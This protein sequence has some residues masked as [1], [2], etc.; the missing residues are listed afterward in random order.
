MNSTSCSASWNSRTT[1]RANRERPRRN[2]GR[3]SRALHGHVRATRNRHAPHRKVASDAART[4]R[5]HPRPHH[6]PGHT[7]TT[8]AVATK[9]QRS[10]SWPSMNMAETIPT[11]GRVLNRSGTA[12]PTSTRVV[13]ARPGDTTRANQNQPNHPVQRMGETMCSLQEH[14]EREIRARKAQPETTDPTKSAAEQGG[15]SLPETDPAPQEQS[16]VTTGWQPAP[17]HEAAW[18]EKWN[19]TR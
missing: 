6:H 16:S 5:I 8:R 9:G 15:F 18:Q 14:I 4:P 12:A 13:P 7:T 3:S 2:T 11:L 17:D 19:L 10:P 1:T